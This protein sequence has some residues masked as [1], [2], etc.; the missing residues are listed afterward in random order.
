M[1][2]D[3]QDLSLMWPGRLCLLCLPQTGCTGLY[4]HVVAHI[5]QSRS[6]NLIYIQFTW[7]SKFHCATGKAS[8]TLLYYT[9]LGENHWGET[10][11]PNET[12]AFAFL[13]Q[14]LFYLRFLSRS[15][16]NTVHHNRLHQ[17][18]FPWPTLPRCCCFPLF[19][20][21]T[22][23]H[24]LCASER[25]QEQKRQ[26][27]SGVNWVGKERMSYTH[28]LSLVYFLLPTLGNSYNYV[29]LCICI[30]V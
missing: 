4:F 5:T 25:K 11:L 8:R 12:S 7:W 28:D 3:T 23:H 20:Q 16:N 21:N 22:E 13:C 27:N 14:V 29:I 24:M 18:D 26:F 17:L 30:K 6:L 1:F 9:T 19:N 15:L 2:Q 10:F